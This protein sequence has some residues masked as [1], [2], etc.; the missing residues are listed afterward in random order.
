MTLLDTQEKALV[1][2]KMDGNTPQLKIE[3]ATGVIQPTI[4]RWADDFVAAGMASP[5][6]EYYPA[7][8]A[9]FSLS[10]RG[11]SI[12]ALKKRNQKGKAVA[13]SQLSPGISE[14]SSKEEK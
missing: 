10:E 14:Q 4:S 5:P 1:Y 9:L 3:S 7:H 12:S 6:N 13:P 11:I 8:R 2:S